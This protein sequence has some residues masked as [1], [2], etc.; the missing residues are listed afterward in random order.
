M[1]FKELTKYGFNYHRIL[2]QAK[3]LKYKIKYEL[4]DGKQR[5]YPYLHKDEMISLLMELGY[6]KVETKN[7]SYFV[8][9]NR[10]K[11]IEELI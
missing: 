7:D 10:I 8:K 9:T 5:P 11:K 4:E 3:K 6:E 1:K 2:Q